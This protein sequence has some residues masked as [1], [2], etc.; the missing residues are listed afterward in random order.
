MT[1]LPHIRLSDAELEKLY[2]KALQK[3]KEAKKEKCPICG[4]EHLM[5]EWHLEWHKWKE[6]YGK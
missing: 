6:K 1:D 5:L 3:P 4:E 2:G